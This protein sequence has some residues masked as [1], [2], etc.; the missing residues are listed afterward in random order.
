MSCCS[1]NFSSLSRWLFTELDDLLSRLEQMEQKPSRVFLRMADT[2]DK[3]GNDTDVSKP[4]RRVWSKRSHKMK[5]V[6]GSSDVS[7]FFV[8]GPTDAATIQLFLL[9]R[10]PQ[11]RFCSYSLSP[12][13]FAALSR[14]QNFHSDQRLMLETPRWEMSDNEGNNLSHAE[15]ERQRERIV[16]FFLVVRDG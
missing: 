11:G 3:N 15:V 8:N 10:L 1:E 9:S 16:S 14:P 4:W 5:K 13:H 6:W 7:Q 2:S 12:W